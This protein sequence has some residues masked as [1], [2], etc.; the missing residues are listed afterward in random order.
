ME[1]NQNPVPAGEAPKRS[2]GPAIGIIVIVILLIIGAFYVWGGKLSEEKAPAGADDVS[3]IEADLSGTDTQ[4]DLSG[5][6][7]IE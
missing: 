5:L 7:T 2:F 4:I 6:D 1:P 3:S